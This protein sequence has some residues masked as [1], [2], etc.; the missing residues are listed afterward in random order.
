MVRKQVYIEER[1]E[2]M[3]KKLSRELNVSQAELIRRG[4]DEIIDQT[5][6]QARRMKAWEEF[7]EFAMSRPEVPEGGKRTWTRDE[8]YD[9]PKKYFSGQ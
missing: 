5:A 3:L 4:I 9:R 7:K 8:L 2:K 6:T 1:Q